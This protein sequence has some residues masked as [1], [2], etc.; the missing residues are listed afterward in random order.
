MVIIAEVFHLIL[1]FS[2]TRWAKSSGNISKTSIWKKMVHIK[3]IEFQMHQMA[4]LI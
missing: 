2:Y 3:V 4:L 1:W